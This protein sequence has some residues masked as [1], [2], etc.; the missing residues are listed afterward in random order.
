MA[1]DVLERIG[2]YFDE[3]YKIRVLDPELAQQTSQL[4]DECKEFVDRIT[5]FQ[6][7]VESFIHLVAALAEEVEREKMKAIGSRNLLKSV[8]KHREFQ[9]QQLQALITEKKLQLERLRIQHEA[10][11]KEEAEQKEFME[12]FLLH[13]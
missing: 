12:S 9:Q 8:A 10:L 1:S 5:K 7:I 13:S 11:R 6:E 4:K 3:L 2:L